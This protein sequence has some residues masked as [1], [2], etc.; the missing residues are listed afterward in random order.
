[1]A[2]FGRPPLAA[3]AAIRRIGCLAGQYLGARRR[4]RSLRAWCRYPSAPCRL[5]WT[6]WREILAF[7]ALPKGIPIFPDEAGDMPGRYGC[8]FQPRCAVRRAHCGASLGRC[9]FYGFSV[10]LLPPWCQQPSQRRHEGAARAARVL[11]SDPG[12]TI[13]AWIARGGQSSAKLLIEGLR[14]AGL[15][16]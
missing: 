6:R 11:E 5:S 13:S 3:I 7:V 8:P 1:M 2:Q 14:K 9:F 15:P 12:F 10:P 4:S 16:E